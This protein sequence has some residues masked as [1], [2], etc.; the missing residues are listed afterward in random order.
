M[1]ITN[2]IPEEMDDERTMLQNAAMNDWEKYRGKDA[3]LDR[4]IAEYT[5]KSVK[6]QHAMK[7]VHPYYAT[8]YVSW[9]NRDA[10]ATV[11]FNGAELGIIDSRNYTGLYHVVRDAREIGCALDLEKALF[12]AMLHTIDLP[13]QWEH[14]AG[15][16][17]FWDKMPYT[18]R[19]ENMPVARRQ[20]YIRETRKD[21]WQVVINEQDGDQLIILPDTER[22]Y[23]FEFD[24]YW[25]ARKFADAH[26]GEDR[27]KK[28]PYLGVTALQDSVFD[29]NG[30]EHY[31]NS[32]RIIDGEHPYWKSLQSS[33]DDCDDSLLI[34]DGRDYLVFR[35]TAYYGDDR[36]TI[37]DLETKEE[38]AVASSYDKAFDMLNSK[39]TKRGA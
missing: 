31:Q 28:L 18:T 24:G 15:A 1:D 7:I 20:A 35:S 9:A 13:T 36:F 17:T 4:H 25:K 16:K 2:D 30:I 22:E 27:M 23:R 33:T 34:V 29:E 11:K 32:K 8:R 6:S 21:R 39:L 12:L 38:M 26:C 37:T 14:I 19:L 10:Y 3:L 5:A